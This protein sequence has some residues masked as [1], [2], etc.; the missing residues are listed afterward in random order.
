MGPRGIRRI[1]R[2]LDV[3][4]TQTAFGRAVLEERFRALQRQIPLLY[5]IALMN[6]I[7]LSFASGAPL[8]G[9]FHPAN[10]L[11]LFVVIRLWHWWW[12]RQRTLSVDQI[13]VEL[14]KTLVLTTV[15]S[16]GFGFWSISLLHEVPA[17]HKDMVILFAS[18]AAIGC[19]YGL[20]TFPQ[21]ARL[22]LLLFA[23]P[24]AF[25]LTSSPKLAHLGVGVSL[26]L[27]TFLIMRLLNVQTER[28]TELVR[29]RSLIEEERERAHRA[30]QLA[31]AEKTRARQ[32]ANSDSLTR[33]ANR[34]ALLEALD[35]RFREPSGP[36]VLALVDLDGFKPINDTFGHAAGDLVLVEVASRLKRAA[37]R[38]LVARTGG[39]EF[40]VIGAHSDR[41]SALAFGESLSRALRAPYRFQ[42][43]EYRISACC[44]VSLLEP[45]KANSAIALARSD[46]AL[47][48]AKQEGRGGVTLY[49]EELEAA[50]R[51]RL[52]MERSLRA[53]EVIEQF[54]LVFQ[55]IY[56]LATGAIRAFEALARWDHP[57]LGRIAPSEFIPIT[58]QIN[59]IEQISETMLAR[60]AAEARRWPEPILLSFNLSAIQLHSAASAPRLLKLAS[61]RGLDPSRL[62]IEVTETALLADF[63]TARLNLDQL[64][65]S[66][67]RIVLDDFGAGFA[68]IAYLREIA[69]DAIKL[70]GRLLTEAVESDSASRLLRGVLE[71]TNS[72]GVPCIAEHIE[73]EAELA[74][75]R[76][77][78]CRDGQG[79]ILSRP[80]TAADARRM[81]TAS[82]V[83][84]PA[85][86]SVPATSAA[87]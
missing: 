39:D 81:A 32:V 54:S 30:E 80:I 87:A 18:L 14:R 6:F 75:L 37:P 42:G 86:V 17:H 40:A 72:L 65:E 44:G 79:Y 61:A 45:A 19:A 26:G 10:I 43:R 55:P 7:G 58:E 56:D 63:E 15:L 78:G 5:C 4:E 21:A 12:T 13:V 77:L 27:I 29:S 28:F 74:L 16:L 22:P 85:L 49:S 11:I 84:K 33:L 48:R 59:V 41:E 51:R 24:L 57:V 31:L 60:A 70:D 20:T 34:R 67:V 52:E 83:K 53:P 25:T 9:P 82:G 73:T 62:Q 35:R 1:W 2:I 3:G 46:A 38:A 71:L 8:T 69:F 64:R 47:Y 23:M 66:G 68:S 50:N 76:R 36:F